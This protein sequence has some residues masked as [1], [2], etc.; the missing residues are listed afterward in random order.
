MLPK[1]DSYGPNVIAIA[2]EIS[3]VIQY[4]RLCQSLYLYYFIIDHH[5]EIKLELLIMKRCPS[6]FD[7]LDL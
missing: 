5:A 1:I 3:S 6:T 4:L 7:Y 2:L